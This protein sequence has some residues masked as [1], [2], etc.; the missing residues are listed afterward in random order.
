MKNFTKLYAKD[1]GITRLKEIIKDEK[2]IKLYTDNENE[3]DVYCGLFDKR[4]WLDDEHVWHVYPIAIEEHKHPDKITVDVHIVCPLCGMIH[5]HGTDV[6]NEDIKLN[7]DFPISDI[8]KRHPRYSEIG[9]RV[10][11]CTHYLWT[12]EKS[13]INHGYIIEDITISQTLK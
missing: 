4:S 9:H 5:T 6:E 7:E 10:Y 11:H 12:P 13:K 3:S 8:D 2:M 1:H